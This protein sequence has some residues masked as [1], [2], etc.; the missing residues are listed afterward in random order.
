MLTPYCIFTRVAAPLLLLWVRMRAAKGKEDISRLS[1]RFGHAS[2]PR[3]DGPLLW[4]HA[5]SVGESQTVLPLLER[6]LNASADLTILI[7]TGTV[8]SAALL[9]RKPVPR[10]LHQYVPLDSPEAVSRFLAHWQ[11]NLAFWMESEFWPNLLLQTQACC[12]LVLLN[13]RISERSINN[14]LRFPKAART[15]MQAFSLILASSEENA[16]RLRRIGA[17][18]VLATG[19]MKFS[20]PALGYSAPA[21]EQLRLE[22]AGRIVWLAA[23]THPGEERLIGDVHQA[24]AARHPGLLTILVPR[25]PM[26]G[27]SIAAELEDMGLRV[28]RRSLKE[29]VVAATHIYLA[30]TMGELGL[31]YRLSP[32]AFIGGSLVPHGGQNPFE[33]ARLGACVLYGPHMHN[34]NDFCTVLEQAGAAERVDS[35]AT[36]AHAVDKLLRDSPLRQARSTAG[37]EAVEA[38]SD[39]EA[40]VWN[41]IQPFCET[42]LGF[43]SSNPASVPRTVYP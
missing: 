22:M 41:A 27:T 8:T 18:N 23:S 30:D 11:P 24:L 39:V 31:L 43:S 7:T 10:L 19:N 25:H 38:Q 5:A 28:A 42:Q 20:S 36:L 6:M 33:P 21:L 37:R 35:A 9:A 3:P 4:V 26:R 2:L 15:M 32:I 34:F 14:W 16:A 12:P 13:G 29:P 40:H 17:Q 1:E